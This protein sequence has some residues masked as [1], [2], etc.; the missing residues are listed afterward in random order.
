MRLA[1]ALVLLLTLASAPAAAAPAGQA[2][3]LTSAAFAPGT[4]IPRR[5]SSYD[6]NHSPP[7]N[8]TKVDGA[9]AYALTLL[10]P[11]SPSGTFTH[12]LAWNIPA[13]ATSLPEDGLAGVSLGVNDAGSVGYFGPHPPYGLHH[14]HFQIIALDARLSLPNGAGLSALNAAMRG[15][16][17]AKGELIGTFKP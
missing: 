11:D 14:Y 8:W 15:H 1:L 7:L 2:I 6:A 9:R 4:P 5:Y 17:I 12:W 10:D 16:V 3:Q 13:T